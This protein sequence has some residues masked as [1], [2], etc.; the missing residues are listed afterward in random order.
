MTR[1]RTIAVFLTKN[2]VREK[3]VRR[4]GCPTCWHI[5]FADPRENLCHFCTNKGLCITN[6]IA[7]PVRN[8]HS[9]WD[10]PIESLG[11]APHPEQTNL[12]TS[13]GEEGTHESHANLA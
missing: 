1:P 10:P 7:N 5:A 11:P 12:E 6:L 13:R 2:L 4:S 8:L 9:N 3:G